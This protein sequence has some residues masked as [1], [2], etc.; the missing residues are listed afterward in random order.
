MSY[1]VIPQLR[2][3]LQNAAGGRVNLS[4][5]PHARARAFPQF[6]M[7]DYL[8][9]NFSAMRATTLAPKLPQAAFAHAY[10]LVTL[11]RARP[12]FFSIL[13]SLC[14][15]RLSLNLDQ[16]RSDLVLRSLHL[17]VRIPEDLGNN[18]ARRSRPCA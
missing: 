7:P 9:L 8:N 16:S 13:L 1:G 15:W 14:E 11:I 12:R 10:R 2:A 5:H 6:S 3:S 4:Y 17:L 18:T